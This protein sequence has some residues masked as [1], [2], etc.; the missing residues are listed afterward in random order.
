MKRKVIR[1]F[2]GSKNDRVY[3]ALVL[4]AAFDAEKGIL[5][6]EKTI[7]VDSTVYDAVD[8]DA[9]IELK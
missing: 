5:Y 3:F 4:G 9:E 6:A 8:E 7:W 1:K 2:T